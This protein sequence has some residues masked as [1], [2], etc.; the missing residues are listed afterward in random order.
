MH[1]G[2]LF[3][4]NKMCLHYRKLYILNLE[5]FHPKNVINSASVSQQEKHLLRLT[6]PLMTEPGNVLPK[7]EPNDVLSD[8]LF[9][10]P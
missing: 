5:K 6:V 10:S 8:L 9:N 4:Q 1:P 3:Y 7:I 2:W